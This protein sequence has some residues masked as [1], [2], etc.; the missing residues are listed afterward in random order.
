M[1]RR[2]AALLLFATTFASPALAA[3]PEDPVIAVMDVAKA[4]WS[5]TATEGMDYFEPSRLDTLYSKAFAQAYRE[6]AKYPIYDEG[7]GPFGYDVITNGQDGC[8]LKDV[9]IS[10]AGE[11]A[12]VTDVKV[13]FKLWTC[14]EDGSAVK[15][16]V[17]EV[18]FDVIEENGRPVIA[19]IHRLTEGTSDSLLKEMQDIAKE[20]ASGANDAVPQA[21]IV[22]GDKPADPNTKPLPENPLGVGN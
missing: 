1:F 17:S 13:T 5:D 19:D 7:G 22:P 21:E 18:H 16:E 12:G 10:K 2:L 20:G 9:T 4:L 15:D 11:K 8:P 14:V 6:A 3:G